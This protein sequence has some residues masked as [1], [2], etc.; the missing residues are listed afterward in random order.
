MNRE[1]CTKNMKDWGI[2]DATD[3]R[4]AAFS[5]NIGLL[6]P[7]EQERLSRA[8]VAIPGMGGV[9]GVTLPAALLNQL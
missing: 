2:S 3:Y 7:G 8:R 1:E 6:S 5:R 4:E 9:G